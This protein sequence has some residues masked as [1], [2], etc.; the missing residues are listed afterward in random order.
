MSCLT[1][2]KKIK[3]YIKGL[4][5]TLI[6]F[7]NQSSASDSPAMRCDARAPCNSYIYL[8]TQ[9][10][11]MY[12]EYF[13]VLVVNMGKMHE[14]A[15]RT[16]GISLNTA[17]T[18]RPILP[19]RS[20][21]TGAT[22]TTTATTTTTVTS[23]SPGGLRLGRFGS[24]WYQFFLGS[25]DSMLHRPQA[26]TPSFTIVSYPVPSK[27]QIASHTYFIIISSYV[28]ENMKQDAAHEPECSHVEH[29]CETSDLNSLHFPPVTV[30]VHCRLWNA[31]EGGV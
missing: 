16:T 20:T 24:L 12:F 10:T 4:W 3:G 21:T 19:N 30:P 22:E 8:Q 28:L 26:P 27:E 15:R 18:L 1:P 6:V 5:F 14:N 31:K 2:P 11:L 9:G 7:Q 29:Y 13:W 25:M 23:A 17:D